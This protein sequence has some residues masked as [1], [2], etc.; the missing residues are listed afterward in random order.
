MGLGSTVGT[1]SVSAP[2]CLCRIVLP[3]YVKGNSDPAVVSVLLP[4]VV[5]ESRSWRSVHSRHFSC[6]PS[7]WSHV[8]IGHYVYEPLVSGS[9]CSLSGFTLHG[10]MLGSTVGACYASAPGVFWKVFFVKVNS[11]P[12]IDSRPAFLGPHSLEKCAQF[13]LR[14][15]GLLHFEI[16]TLFP[17]ASRIWQP[18]LI[19]LVLHQ[20]SFPV[21]DTG[22]VAGSPGVSTPR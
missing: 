11:F 14:V 16:W 19:V 7:L 13:P 18:L 17:R 9:S 10:A 20:K 5:C 8:E 12:E 1:W 15:A 3:F 6:L 4:G 21:S 2:R 22:G